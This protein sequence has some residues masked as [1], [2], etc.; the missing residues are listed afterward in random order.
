MLGSDRVAFG[1]CPNI[2]ARPLVPSRYWVSLAVNVFALGAGRDDRPGSFMDGCWMPMLRVEQLS[3]GHIAVPCNAMS[4]H[5]VQIASPSLSVVKAAF[6]CQLPY[7]SRPNSDSL[8]FGSAL[9][10]RRR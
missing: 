8:L 4:S 10:S 3:P 7:F 2:R 9:N 1:A 6:G 5:S